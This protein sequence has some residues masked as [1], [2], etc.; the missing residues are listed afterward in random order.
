MKQNISF[1]F[2][3]VKWPFWFLRVDKKCSERGGGANKQDSAWLE[4]MVGVRELSLSRITWIAQPFIQILEQ[5]ERCGL[6]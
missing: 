4:N 6:C 1:T 5:K 2:I 3:W